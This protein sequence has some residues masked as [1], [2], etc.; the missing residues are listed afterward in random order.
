MKFYTA[1]HTLGSCLAWKRTHAPVPSLSSI[2]SQPTLPFTAW[3]LESEK[4]VITRPPLA[5]RTPCH[6]RDGVTYDG[7]TYDGATYDGVTETD[8]ASALLVQRR[9][10]TSAAIVCPRTM[11]V[12]PCVLQKASMAARPYHMNRGGCTPGGITV[13]NTSSRVSSTTTTRTRTR[14]STSAAQAE[15]QAEGE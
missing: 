11:R 15:A 4:T 1:G 9:P 5:T 7:A 13:G 2:R 10:R 3:S 8:A 12:M 6:R 14:I